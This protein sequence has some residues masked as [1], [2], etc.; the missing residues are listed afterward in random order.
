[1]AIR[2][3]VRILKSNTLEEFRQKSNEL[4]IYFALPTPTST[5]IGWRG[6]VGR[7]GGEAPRAGGGGGGT[8]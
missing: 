2:D 4:S 5:T 1:M 3:D 7:G 8:P 6:W